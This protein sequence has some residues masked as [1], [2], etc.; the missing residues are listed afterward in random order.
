MIERLLLLESRSNDIYANLALEQYLAQNVKSARC[1]LFLWRNSP[2]VVIGRNQ[3]AYRECRTDLLDRM[4]VKLSR[5]L[6]GGG[7]VYQDLGNLN[8][9]F[10]TRQEDSDIKKQQNVILEACRSLGVDARLSGRNDML[11]GERKFSGNSFYTHDGV[12]FHNGTLLLD[13]DMKPMEKCLSPS[14]LKLSSKAVSSVRSRVVN[15]HDLNAAIDSK[16]MCKAVEKAFSM[17]Y[18]LDVQRFSYD[19]IDMEDL[20]KK[21]QFFSSYDWIYGKNADFP[22][23]VRGR[24]A[25]GEISVSLQVRNAVCSDVKVYTDAL[26]HRLAPVI[27]DAL[28]GAR[29]SA[30]ELCLRIEGAQLDTIYSNDICSMLQKELG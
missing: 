4:G 13:V 3:N 27:E 28:R 7:A 8:F 22:L 25:W 19:S 11:V 9:T 6:S 12:G 2:C 24:F 14:D 10:C 29:F 17:V 15:L 26:D 5:R 30:S 23:T 1:I 16:T 21:R 18:G 20:E